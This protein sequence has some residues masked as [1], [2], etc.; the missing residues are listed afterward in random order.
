LKRIALEGFTLAFPVPTF[1]IKVQVHAQHATVSGL[2][3]WGRSRRMPLPLRVWLFTVSA[4]LAAHGIGR[5]AAA[6]PWLP[7]WAGALLGVCA[8]VCLWWTMAWLDR[9]E[10]HSAAYLALPGAGLVGAAIAGLGLL[11]AESL[12]SRFGQS[13]GTPAGAEKRTADPGS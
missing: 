8:S 6:R 9:Q 4:A 3:P 7:A 11:L 5:L 2:P 12:R 1:Q 10:P 13:L